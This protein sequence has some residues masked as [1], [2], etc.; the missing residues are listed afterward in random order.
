MPES[1]DSLSTERRQ[2]IFLSLVESQDTGLSVPESRKQ[3]AAKFAVAEAVV[4]EIEREGLENGWPP[5]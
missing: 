3:A 5:L 4:K 1:V 2:E